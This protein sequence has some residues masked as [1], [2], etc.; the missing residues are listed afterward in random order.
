[1]ATKLTGPTVVGPNL[2]LTFPRNDPGI[3]LGSVVW[4]EEGKAYRYVQ[5]AD[6]VTYAHGHVVTLASVDGTWK[7]TND[8]AGG[9]D[10]AGIAVGVVHHPSDLV[11][12]KDSFGWV[13][14]AGVADVLVKGGCAAGDLLVLSSTDGAAAEASYDAVEGLAHADLASFAVALAAIE[15]NKTGKVLLRGLI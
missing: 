10:V 8:R 9:S 1:M 15:D 3:Q 13:Q 11:P 12:A 14:V 2:D 7:V 6:N 4:G 5:F